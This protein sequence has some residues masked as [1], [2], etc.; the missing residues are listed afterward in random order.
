MNTLYISNVNNSI[1]ADIKNTL[2]KKVTFSTY[3]DKYGH[4]C[5]L[6]SLPGSTFELWH[7]TQKDLEGYW[8]DD[9][10]ESVGKVVIGGKDENGNRRLFY[11]E[12]TTLGSI[13]EQFKAI[14]KMG[15]TKC[16]KIY[17]IERIYSHTP[18]DDQY[19]IA[20]SYKWGIDKEILEDA[21]IRGIRGRRVNFILN[22]KHIFTV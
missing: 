4:N 14:S 22:G 18:E 7:F 12:N 21:F 6:C 20:C 9:E 19:L 13:K 3:K 1:D 17:T 8:D 10:V 15:Y 2:N 5:E 16:H 11:C